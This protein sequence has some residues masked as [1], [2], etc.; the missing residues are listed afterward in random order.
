MG[1]RVI[2][3]LKYVP[4]TDALCGD[5]GGVLVVVCWWWCGWLV[6]EEIRRRR[7]KEASYCSR[8]LYVQQ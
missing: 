2:E 1:G 8:L 3:V 6:G 5:G 7:K 4:C